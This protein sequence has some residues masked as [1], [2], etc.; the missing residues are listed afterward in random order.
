MCQKEII[1]SKKT[2]TTLKIVDNPK[3][4]PDR[5]ILTKIEDVCVTKRKKND[6]HVEI[7]IGN[8]ETYEIKV[9]TR[10]IHYGDGTPREINMNK[11]LNKIKSLKRQK[12]I[13]IMEWD[14]LSFRDPD[15]MAYLF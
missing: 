15:T 8:G 14:T 2:R 1:M 3:I 4:Y 12:I 11:M 13:I 6:A 10:T 9:E 5:T 7:Q